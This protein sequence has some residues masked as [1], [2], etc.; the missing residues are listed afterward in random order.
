MLVLHFDYTSPASAVAVLRLQGLAD[1][2]AH[3]QF[4]GIDVLGLEASLP[5]TLDQL[6]ELERH[7]P[8]AREL[9][10]TMQR[11]R[12]RS[13][14]L[15]AHVVGTL[16]DGRGLG[17]AWRLAALEAYWS[18][19]VDLADDAALADLAV[20]IGLDR[21]PVEEALADR[22]YRASLRRAMTADRGRGIGG[23]PVLEFEGTFVPADLGD[24][25]L[26]QLAAL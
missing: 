14:T 16:A 11:P 15:G 17:A 19:G 3:V 20:R 22:P 1:R 7:A 8:R 13:A 4:S 10:L 5:V 9:G 18:H 24:D 6:E 23:V 26:R 21:R 25:D 2:G 12:L